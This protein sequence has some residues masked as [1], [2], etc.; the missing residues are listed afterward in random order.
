MCHLIIVGCGCSG[1]C[2]I[3]R[4]RCVCAGLGCLFIRCW[5]VAAMGRSV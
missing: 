5:G 3:R 1:K 2:D 4:R